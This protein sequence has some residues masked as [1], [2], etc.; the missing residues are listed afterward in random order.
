MERTV[1]GR[2][3]A[4]TAEECMAR[5]SEC[6]RN[7]AVA[8]SEP[9]SLEFLKLAAQW[10]AMAVRLIYLGPLDQPVGALAALN[11]LAAPKT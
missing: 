7:A 6:A 1:T 11:G 2:A 4:M 5:A 9:V 3:E 8:V 10:R